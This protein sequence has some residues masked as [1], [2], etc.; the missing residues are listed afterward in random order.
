MLVSKSL[1]F[2]NFMKQLMPH[3]LLPPSQSGEQDSIDPQLERQVETIR[4]LVD[5]Y[6]SIVSKNIRDSV[7]KSIMFMM[8][9]KV[10]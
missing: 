7:P 8:V 10:S 9:N 6:F 5:S 3:I 2:G 1:L 4:N